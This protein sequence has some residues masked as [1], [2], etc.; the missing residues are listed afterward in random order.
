MFDPEH[1]TVDE[2][3][4]ALRQ[5]RNDLCRQC[6]NDLCLHCGRYREA[7][8]GACDGCFYKMAT[9]GSVPDA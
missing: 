5:C 4:K 9:E 3:K 2:L 7:H 8:K 1:M 6:R